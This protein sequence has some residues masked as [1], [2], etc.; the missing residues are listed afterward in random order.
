MKKLS[1]VAIVLST[2]TL[3]VQI[4]I[5][6]TGKTNDDEIYTQALKNDYRIYSPVL[7]DTI[8]FA[9]ELVPMD[10]YYVREALDRE[11]L[12]NMYW[13]TNTILNMKRAYRHFPVIEPILKKHGVPSDLKYLAVI[14]SGLLNVTSPAKA[15]GYWQFIKATG[16]KYGLEITDEVDMRNSLEASTEAACKFLKALYA[17][18]GSWTLAAAAYNCGENGLQRQIN[19]Q[20]VNNY[21][22]LRL[23]SETARYVYRI[24]AVKLIMQDPQ[25]YGFNLRYKDMYPQIPYRT[26]ELKG[27][28]VDLYDFAKDNGT[29]YKMLREM[30]PWLI[31]NKLVNKENKTYIVK[32]PIENGTLLKNIRKSDDMKSELVTHL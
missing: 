23:N 5:F 18:F 28:N 20:S 14:E 12:S 3:S 11:I 9:G 6:A 13:H 30:N 17:Q 8:K 2:L 7:P 25:S 19:L 22:D 21:Y 27:Q 16:K 31:T 10:V 24:V 4:F 32:L 26:V 29:T 15:Q 1:I